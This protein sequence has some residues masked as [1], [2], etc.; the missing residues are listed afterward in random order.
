VALWS[1]PPEEV[2]NHV[3]AKYGSNPTG[4]RKLFRHCSPDGAGVGS[5]VSLAEALRSGGAKVSPTDVQLLLQEVRCARDCPSCTAVFED[6]IAPL[7]IRPRLLWNPRQ[8]VAS[9]PEGKLTFE[10]L[11]QAVAKLEGSVPNLRG[12]AAL[13]WAPTPDV[14][15]VGLQP[16]SSVT[17]EVLCRFRQAG[18]Q[19]LRQCPRAETSYGAF[20][21]PFALVVPALCRPFPPLPCPCVKRQAQAAGVQ[22]SLFKTVRKELA[23][24]YDLPSQA[25]LNLKGHGNTTVVDS[26]ITAENLHR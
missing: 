21:T 13:A 14:F 12:P 20:G 11:Q 24:C 5:V 8:T 17:S 7:L 6:P 22:R 4:L 18:R 1:T 23:R 3:T 16:R 9:G 10:Q 19:L 26:V 15:E 25:F 2:L